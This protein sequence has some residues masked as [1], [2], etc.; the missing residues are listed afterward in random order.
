MLFIVLHLIEAALLNIKQDY[1]HASIYLP[2]NHSTTS[3][4]LCSLT[5]GLNRLFW[6]SILAFVAYTLLDRALRRPY[7]SSQSLICRNLALLLAKYTFLLAFASAISIGDDYMLAKFT[8]T[9]L[10]LSN[11]LL[12][13]VSVLAVRTTDAERQEL[14]AMIHRINVGL[15]QGI[16]HMWIVLKAQLNSL[17][18]ILGTG[19]LISC[20]IS[21]A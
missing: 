16:Q 3:I 8:A 6:A 19:L 18:G 20:F 15:G 9:E 1:V 7:E 13:L 12:I 11:I 14:A 2:T 17:M 21:G 10:V 4:L 5:F